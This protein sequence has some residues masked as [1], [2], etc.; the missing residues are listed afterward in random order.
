MQC[1]HTIA[2]DVN[3]DFAVDISDAALIGL[4]WQKTVPLATA[5]VDINGDGIIDI[6]DASL[7]GLNWQKHV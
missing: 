3:G 1:I 5:N 6:M 2:G 7:V 4:N